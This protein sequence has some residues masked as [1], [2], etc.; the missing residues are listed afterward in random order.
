MMAAARES[1]PPDLRSAMVCFG[2]LR[3]R[4]LP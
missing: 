2:D 3:L 4:L 1:R